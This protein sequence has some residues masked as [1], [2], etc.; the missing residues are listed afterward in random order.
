MLTSSADI[1]I[2]FDVIDPDINFSD[3]LPIIC[4]VKIKENQTEGS[5][6]VN[7]NHNSHKLTQ[8]RWD[9]ADLISYYHNT[10]ERLKPILASIEDLYCRDGLSDKLLNCTAVIDNIYDNIV[11]IMVVCA[12][13]FVPHCQKDFLKYWWDEEMDLLKEASIESNRIW[14]DAGKPKQGPI[15]VKRQSCRLQYR[16]RIRENQNQALSAYS[17]DLHDALIAKNGTTFW[18]VWNSKFE[19]KRKPLDIEGS[20]DPFT[21]ADKFANFFPV[22]LS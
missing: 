22:L 19:K 8:L 1:V 11:N 7:T 18:K 2:N 13:Q 20:S 10:G 21:I 4:S 6:H 16:N 14:K 3:R 5:A 9:R 15:F 12:N 17:N